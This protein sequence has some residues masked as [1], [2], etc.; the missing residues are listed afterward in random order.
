MQAGLER[1]STVIALGGGVVGDLAG[2]AAAVYLRGVRWVALPT[3]LLA[4]VDASLGGKTGC[5]L[6]QGKNLIGAFHP[7]SLVLADPQ[8]LSTL[9]E[10]ELRNGLAE[11]VKHGILADPDLFELCSRG[12]RGVAGR[13]GRRSCGRRWRSS[14]ASSRKILTSAAAR[15]AEPGAYPGAC[16]GAGLGLPDQAWRGGGDRHARRRAPG[17]ADRAGQPGLVGDDRSGARRGWDLPTD[18]PP[19]LERERILAA[20]RLDK[21][22]AVGQAA[23]GAARAHRRVPLGV[24]VDDPAQL[25]DMV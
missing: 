22:R 7:P 12:W 23:A 8:V 18:M 14:C 17:R 2:F 10:V 19:G 20:M 25:L 6:P 15:L 5:D 9:P 3:S 21:K 24:E 13:A 1:G 4:M 16:A 11:V